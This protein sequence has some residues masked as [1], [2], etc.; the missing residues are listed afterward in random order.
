MAT[1]SVKHHAQLY[2]Y[3]TYKK[4]LTGQYFNMQLFIHKVKNIDKLNS[5]ISK[6]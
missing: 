1:V 6:T 2:L 3:C 5:Y 4:L